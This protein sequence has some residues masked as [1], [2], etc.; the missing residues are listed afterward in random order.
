MYIVFNKPFMYFLVTSAAASLYPRRWSPHAIS[1]HDIHGWV[2][3]TWAIRASHCCSS[4]WYWP[5]ISDH[6][7][8][9]TFRTPWRLPYSTPFIIST[10]L[11]VVS[12]GSETEKVKIIIIHTCHVICILTW[13]SLT[14]YTFVL[15]ATHQEARGDKSWLAQL[16]SSHPPH[17]V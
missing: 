17:T 2:D 4:L 11:C 7:S 9:G 6:L 5:Q 8:Y 1:F 12:V 15:L 10:T 3:R 16:P 13:N 14:I